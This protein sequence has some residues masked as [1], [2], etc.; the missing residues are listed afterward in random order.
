MPLPL[1]TSSSNQQITQPD[2]IKACMI[3]LDKESKKKDNALLQL[4][5]EGSIE[6][7]GY[8]THVKCTIKDSIE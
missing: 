8:L 7:G 4:T 3:V 2:A 5:I 1:G 6:S